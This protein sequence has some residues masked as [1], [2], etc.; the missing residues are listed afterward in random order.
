MKVFGARC[1][2]KK[3][4]KKDELSS[5]IIL[6]G[7]SKEPTYHGY[8]IAVGNGAMLENGTRVPMDI[9]VGDEVVYTAFSGSPIVNGGEEYIILNE[10]DI[11]AVLNDDESK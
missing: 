7:R 9:K 5:G 3:I 1:I 2:V 6:Q 4:K 11:L 10:R 8:V